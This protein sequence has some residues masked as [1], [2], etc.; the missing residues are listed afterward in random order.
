MELTLVY[1]NIDIQE[2]DMG[3]GCVPCEM[4][5]ISTVEPFKEGSEGVRTMAPKQEYV[6]DKPQP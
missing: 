1:A 3:G 6:I 2:F 5:G 4:D